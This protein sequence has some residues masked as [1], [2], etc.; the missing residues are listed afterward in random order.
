MPSCF[1]LNLGLTTC[2]VFFFES[3]RSIV[4]TGSYI[5]YSEKKVDVVKFA[6]YVIVLWFCCLVALYRDSDYQKSGFIQ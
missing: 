2:S 4:T 5:I 6:K 1:I 3:I